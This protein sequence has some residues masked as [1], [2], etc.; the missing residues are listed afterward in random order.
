MGLSLGFISAVRL[1]LDVES[2]IVVVFGLIFSLVFNQDGLI[3][4]EPISL[5]DRCSGTL[6]S[7]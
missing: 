7:E 4:K 1:G 3:R 2:E 5:V 6:R